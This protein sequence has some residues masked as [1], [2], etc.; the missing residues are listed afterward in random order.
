MVI[1]VALW[2]PPAE[3]NQKGRLNQLMADKLRFSQGLLHG[4]ALA[5]FPKI[6]SNA[7]DLLALSKTAEWLANNAPR[8]Q[9]H[10][11]AFQVAAETLIQK[12]K[13]NNIDGV[14]LAFQDLT[15]SCVRCHQYLREVRDARAPAV[16]NDL[17]RLA[18]R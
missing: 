2:L 1:V 12:A 5:D 6:I 13:N 10:S 15:M 3:G 7:E 8:Y 9:V 11:N 16:G 18:R 17:I 14:V 4:I